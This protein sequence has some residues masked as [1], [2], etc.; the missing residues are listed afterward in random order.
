MHDRA[1]LEQARAALERHKSNLMESF[2]AT[3]IGIGKDEVDGGHV[4]SVYL[5]TGERFPSERV[6]VDG[7]PLRF[8][9]TGPI[10]PLEET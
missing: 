8:V 3:G 2:G 9:V 1:T 4:I 10:K 7:V 5:E 6:V